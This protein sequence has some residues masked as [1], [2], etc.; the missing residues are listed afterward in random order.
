MPLRLPVDQSGQRDFDANTNVLTVIA[1][2]SYDKFAA[3]LQH[4]YQETGDAAPP[5]PTNA[6]RAPALRNEALFKSTEFRT[7]N[8]GADESEA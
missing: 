4:E 6:R 1:N 3:Q 7:A 8:G 2:E 5:P